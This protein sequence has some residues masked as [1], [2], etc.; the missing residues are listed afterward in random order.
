MSSEKVD[1]PGAYRLLRIKEMMRKFE[2]E[3]A[4]S[5]D[6]LK[7][8]AK[9]L[10]T[11]RDNDVQL[12]LNP[13]GLLPVVAV[14]GP[15][16]F[17]YD[18]Q[19][20]K[21]GEVHF[22]LFLSEAVLLE[23]GL[24]RTKP[25]HRFNNKNGGGPSVVSERYKRAVL[26][27]EQ[28]KMVWPTLTKVLLG[29]VNE[30]VSRWDSFQS[31]AINE[32]SMEPF[33]LEV[34]GRSIPVER[35]VYVCFDERD[36][37][38]LS[39]FLWRDI[40]SSRT[41]K[42]LQKILKAWRWRLKGYAYNNYTKEE[43]LKGRRV[44]LKEVADRLIESPLPLNRLVFLIRNSGRGS[45]IKNI[46]EEIEVDG[47]G[48]LPRFEEIMFIGS[49]FLSWPDGIEVNFKRYRNG[50]FWFE[51]VPHDLYNNVVKL[52]TTTHTVGVEEECPF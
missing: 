3:Y 34:A 36:T 12:N 19:E 33:F 37:L 20:K 44:H 30:R 10:I 18:R 25:Y 14:V 51:L 23:I 47:I 2:R 16:V 22:E 35:G 49:R 52:H 8:E 13:K 28:L 26:S 9:F 38:L 4:G 39:E 11:I 43:V 24:W 1:I 40:E 32:C 5:V 15:A 46:A 7:R 31:A 6:R 45:L 50:L 27:E 42:Y 17:S 41:Q 48:D 21:V 29:Y